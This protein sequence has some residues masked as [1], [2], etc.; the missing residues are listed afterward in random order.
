M[1]RNTFFT[2]S[3]MLALLLVVSARADY[4]AGQQAWDAGR[5]HEALTQWQ[6]SAATGDRRAM[7]ALG[8]LHLQGLGVLQDYVEA[9]KWFN[10]AASRGDTEALAERDAL[11]E[12]M[13]PAQV[14]EAQALA[15]VWRPGEVQVSS[16]PEETIGGDAEPPRVTVTA[17]PTTGAT[18]AD[19][20][21]ISTETQGAPAAMDS[22]PASDASSDVGPGAALEPKCAA[23]EE[24]AECWKELTDKSGCH[25][26]DNHYFA[27]LTVTWSG[28]CAGGVIVGEGTLV[29]T[30]DGKSTST[31]GTA[32]GTASD[33]KRHGH[34]VYRYADGTVAEGPYVDG[35]KHGDWVERAADGTVAE[36]P[37]VDGKEH[38]KWVINHPKIV[39]EG[40]FV[41]GKEHGN[42]V[43]RTAKGDVLAG[44]YVD[45]KKHGH[46]LKLIFSFRQGAEPS[47]GFDNYDQDRIIGS[48]DLPM[49]ECS[50]IENAGT[51]PST[52]PSEDEASLDSGRRNASGY[53]VVY[54]RWG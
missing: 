51:A 37:Y 20:E 16:V 22:T 48:G 32:S 17:E 52:T 45:G 41:N 47:C 18:S 9:H 30:K 42:W 6:A 35:K 4:E 2:I 13:A 33:G 10:L 43:W 19:T 11:T 1:L 14:A 50:V 40:P 28:P 8:R 39:M 3:V 12:K 26:W 29:W 23:M 34:W 25:V 21:T 27:E 38:G 49:E 44:R 46:W 7:L 53:N 36:G 54:G 31:T 15:R 24:G 5:T